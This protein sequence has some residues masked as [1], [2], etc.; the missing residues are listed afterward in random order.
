MGRVAGKIALITGAGTG[1]GRAAALLLVAEG[2]KVVVTDV[3][4]AAARGTADLIAEN[5]G[6]SVFHRQDVS[7]P[8]DWPVVMAMVAKRF[9]RLDVPVNDAGI[10]IAKNIE[11]TSLAEWRRTMAVNLDGVFFGC[12][13]GIA[14]MKQSGGGSIINCPPSTASSARPILPHI[15][16]PRAACAP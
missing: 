3:E 15:A 4:A 8:E 16:P 9:A 11:D 1:L 10:A 14:M 6:E 7:N 13:Q 2:A 12:Q 5:G